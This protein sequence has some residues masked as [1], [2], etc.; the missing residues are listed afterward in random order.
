MKWLVSQGWQSLLEESNIKHK[1]LVYQMEY[2][3]KDVLVFSSK[4]YTLGRV[5]GDRAA[6]YDITNEW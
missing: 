2:E 4:A 1:V 3:S 5:A 6:R